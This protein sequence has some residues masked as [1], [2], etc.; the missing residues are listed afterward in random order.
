MAQNYWIEVYEELEQ[1]V[2]DCS[3]LAE[4]KSSNP[5][6]EVLE[7]YEDEGWAVIGYKDGQFNLNILDEELDLDTDFIIPT[8]CY[9]PK[10]L[11]IRELRA[12]Y[13]D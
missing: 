10:T 7:D 9:G 6:I 5:E 1:L 4:L 13:F 3:T 11:N 8:E 2:F 12:I